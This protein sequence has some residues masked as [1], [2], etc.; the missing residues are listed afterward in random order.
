MTY[1][2]TLW[3]DYRTGKRTV[4]EA[5]QFFLSGVD[6]EDLSRQ[7]DSM[8][9]DMLRAFSELALPSREIS[10]SM[11]ELHAF[12]FDS[13]KAEKWKQ[14]RLELIYDAIRQR[15]NEQPSACGPSGL[16]THLE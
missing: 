11:L 10:L 9:D 7:I 1:A 12:G 6:E 13:E 14:R 2:Q 5:F 4:A 8:P 15:L 16:D 3:F